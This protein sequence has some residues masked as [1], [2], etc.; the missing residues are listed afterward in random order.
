MSVKEKSQ[1]KLNTAEIKCFKNS[2]HYQR[3]SELPYLGKIFSKY[4]LN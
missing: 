2:N 4:L 1:M 3:I